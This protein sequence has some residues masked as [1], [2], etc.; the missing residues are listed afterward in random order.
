MPVWRFIV[1]NADLGQELS[2]SYTPFLV[3]LSFFV[4]VLG[5]YA[6]LEVVERMASAPAP[7]TRRRWLAAGAAAMG[8]GIW[9][10]HFIGMLAFS[11]PIPVS[12]DLTITLLSMVPAVFA[13]AMAL[14]F[15]ARARISWRRLNVGGLLMALGI[16]SMHYTGMEAMRMDAMMEYEP[17]LFALSIF[18]AHVLA[19]LAL[20]IKFFPGGAALPFIRQ[21]AGAGAMGCA[22]AAMHYTAMHAARFYPGSMGVAKVVFEPRWMAVV[23]AAVTSVIIAVAIAATL[24]DRRTAELVRKRDEAVRENRAKS[25]FLAAM[26]HEIRTPLNG[27]IGMADLLASGPLAPEQRDQAETIRR[28]GQTL[29]AILND[30]LD[31][32]KI[33]AGRLEVERLPVDARAAAADTV[34]LY[35][36]QVREGG[37]ELIL[38]WPETVPRQVLADPIRVR[39]V[40]LNLVSNALKFAPGGTVTVAASASE[41]ERLAIAVRDTGI[42]MDKAQRARLFRPF[43]QGDA[44]TTRRFGGTGLGLAIT[45][46]LLEAMG[47]TIAVASAPGCGSTF[48]VRLP[49][50]SE[51]AI[52]DAAV[53]PVSPSPPTL[54]PGA[55]PRRRRILVAED[56]PVNRK[57]AQAMLEY[58][59]TTVEC[60]E[61]GYEAVE[62]TARAAYDL[63][64]LDIFMPVL[65]GLAAAR[66]IRAREAADGGGRQRLVALTA[67]AFAADREACEAAGMDGFLA[68][69]ITLDS[70]HALLKTVPEGD[71]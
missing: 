9:S 60:V 68:K 15:M 34:A 39:Q 23:I 30:I 49:L 58:L 26:S 38:D 25:D 42:G 40:L 51:P 22:V 44:S 37:G 64:L 43:T 11:L 20:Y 4:A 36:S 1:P 12:Y 6:A 57:V 66:A 70:L 3:V 62:A 18:V 17:V 63:V 14:H 21:V 33:E 45:A 35:R 8:S 53:S 69:P 13:S 7:K 29:L 24:V 48:T 27:V 19:T 2:A 46:R 10:M 41:E 67:N 61:D 55:V 31:W 59:G 65:D 16:G 52:E 32:A 71:G 56:S 28:S 54:Q 47:G 5:G 50:A